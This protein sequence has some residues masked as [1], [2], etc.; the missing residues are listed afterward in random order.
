MLSLSHKV[1]VDHPLMYFISYNQGT[2]RRKQ[3]C[4]IVYNTS[5]LSF[6]SS[7]KN[8]LQDELYV[9]NTTTFA[10]V[11]SVKKVCCRTH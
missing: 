11:S 6:M 10:F 7:V 5:T 3:C 8:V 1:D 9:Y 2:Q 4:V